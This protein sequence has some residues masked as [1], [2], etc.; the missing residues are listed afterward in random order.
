MDLSMNTTTNLTAE[1][2]ASGP[3]IWPILWEY[4]VISLCKSIQANTN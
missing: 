1:I 3:G 4:P 2:L